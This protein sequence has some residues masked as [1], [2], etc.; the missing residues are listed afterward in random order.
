[1]FVWVRLKLRIT[2]EPISPLLKV[3]KPKIGASSLDASTPKKPES[4]KLPKF[5]LPKLLVSSI[6][7][8]LFLTSKLKLN[9]LTGLAKANSSKLPGNPKPTSKLP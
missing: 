5:T 9:P 7:N 1:M 3:L 8:V 2:L 4:P 6:A